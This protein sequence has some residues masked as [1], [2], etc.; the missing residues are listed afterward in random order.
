MAIFFFDVHD[1][2]CLIRD[3]CGQPH[4][5]RSAAREEA[6]RLLPELARD[7]FSDGEGHSLALRVR[8]ETGMV[9]FAATL[10]RS[11]FSPM[12]LDDEGGW[13][14]TLAFVAALPV[15]DELSCG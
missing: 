4:D 11:D 15:S 1:S 8:D 10:S 5:D 7:S 6:L 3:E 9:I 14:E 12:D 13:R 2:E